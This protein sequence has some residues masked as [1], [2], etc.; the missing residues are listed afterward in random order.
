MKEES[1]MI[2]TNPQDREIFEEALSASKREIKG[3]YEEDN[4]STHYILFLEYLRLS[5]MIID[6]EELDFNNEA[7]NY[8]VDEKMDKILKYVSKRMPFKEALGNVIVSLGSF[9]DP[10]DM[11]RYMD[12]SQE[13]LELEKEKLFNKTGL[14]NT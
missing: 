3:F 12:M 4:F 2:L 7:K 11:M 8:E 13:D 14:W 6:L 1:N 10:S 9:P 5:R